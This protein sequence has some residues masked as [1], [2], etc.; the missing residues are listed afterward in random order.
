MPQNG[1]I[2]DKLGVYKSA[3]CG[4]EIVI[5]GGTTF[6]D[7]PNHP[8]HTILWQAK[9]KIVSPAVNEAAQFISIIRRCLT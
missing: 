2:N 6:P 5:R 9:E 7:C 1:E 8:K 4:S 3:C